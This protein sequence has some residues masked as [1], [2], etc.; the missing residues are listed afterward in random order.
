M[1][2]P[3]LLFIIVLM[4]KTAYGCKCNPNNFESEVNVS[5]LIF[6][7]KV[8]DVKKVIN[9]NI[10]VFL[11]EKTWKGKQQDT[12]FLSTGLDQGN[13]G[14]RTEIGENYIVYSSNE[15]VNLCSRTKKA[16]GVIDELR[17]N[18]LF[19][20]LVKSNEIEKINNEENEYIKVLANSKLNYRDK[21][22]V[23]TIN[24]K[25]L[26]KKEW[27]KI[28]FNYDNPSIQIIELNN[29]ERLKYHTDYLF[30]TWSK[31]KVTEKV[32]RRIL[33]QIK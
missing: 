4:S 21:K 5:D 13:C 2:T 8:I 27:F 15:S 22:I 26:N 9:E 33:D 23:F 20:N 30:V 29:E 12:Y 18:Y 17:L 11:T 6:K 19:N 25:I 32:K 31:Q 7:G 16:R 24:H 3:F 10:I 14:L 1:N 28:T